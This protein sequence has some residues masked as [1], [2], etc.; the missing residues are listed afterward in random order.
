MLTKMKLFRQ[1]EKVVEAMLET[2]QENLKLLDEND[3]LL[4]KIDSLEED[5]EEREQEIRELI[6]DNERLAK[7]I[8]F[9]HPLTVYE[10]TLF[11]HYD[12]PNSKG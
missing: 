7:L 6:M 11:R 2:N 5:L 8:E 3:K 10:T 4:K 9:E 12:F 1:T